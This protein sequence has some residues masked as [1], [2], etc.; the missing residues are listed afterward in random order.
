MLS[1]CLGH[2]KAETYPSTTAELTTGL[3]YWVRVMGHKC[4]DKNC[5]HF[6]VADTTQSMVSFGYF[7]GYIEG[8]RVSQVATDRKVIWFPEDGVNADVLVRPFIE[9]LEKEAQPQ[10]Q[11]LPVAVYNFLK[12]RYPRSGS[13]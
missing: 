11:L 12:K 5:A 4:S 3:K 1:V 7:K 10:D 2:S 9:F 6:T 8:F 13:P